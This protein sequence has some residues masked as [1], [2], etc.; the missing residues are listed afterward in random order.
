MAVSYDSLN[1][2]TIM[3]IVLNIGIAFLGITASQN[4]LNRDDIQGKQIALMISSNFLLLI[5]MFMI[6]WILPLAIYV[7][8]I[9]Q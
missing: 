4:Y 5:G 1:V 3:A 2:H 8:Y 9:K 6:L 7:Q